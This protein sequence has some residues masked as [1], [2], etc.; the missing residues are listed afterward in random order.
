MGV[1]QRLIIV[2]F[3]QEVA[4]IYSEKVLKVNKLRKTNQDEFTVSG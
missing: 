2:G 1:M 3:I 4:S